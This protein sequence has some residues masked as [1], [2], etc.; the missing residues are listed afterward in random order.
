MRVPLSWLREFVTVELSPE[1]LAELLTLGGLEVEGV[2]E[3]FE[4]L[5]PVVSAEI[6]SVKPHPEA[7]RL[8]VCEVTDGKARYTI[9]SGAPG[10][11]KG[12]KVALALPG[13]VTFS[14][15]K[16]AETRIRGVTSQGMLLSPYE[17]GVSAERDR[18]LELPREAPLG[19][20]FYE[21]LG[22]SEPVL[23]V[24]ITP[25]R[26]DCLS[27]L[28]VAREV[29]A[30]TGAE[31]RRPEI[32]D[33]PMGDEIQREA[34]VEILDPD[35]CRR[36][37]GRLIKGVSVRESPFEIA[38]RLWMCGLR[39]INN[40]VDVT[41]YV[42][43]ELGQPLH[44]FDWQKIEGRRI[45]V[46]RAKE[47]EQ[48]LTLD[49]EKRL[50]SPEMLVIADSRRPVAVAGVMGGEETGVGEETRE[51]FLESAWF[52]TSSIRR[53]ARAL[54]L[55][56]DSSYRFE[57]GVDPE[58]V[59]RALERAAALILETAG[60][61]IVPG[62]LDLYPRPYRAPEIT[63]R[64]SR[65]KS[66]LRVELNREEVAGILK[67]TGGEVEVQGE[68]LRYKPPSFRYDLSLEED[69]IE[70]VARIYGYDR[71]PVS[72]PVVE[73][74]ARAPER[75]DLLISRTREVLRALGF[76]EVINYSFIS[77]ET[78]SAL[79][80]P[81]GDLRLRPL[82]LA[83]PLSEAQ[84]VMRTMLLPGLLETARFNFFREVSRLKIFEVGRVF[85]P[86]EGKL[87]EE[88]L[89]LGILMMGAAEPDFWKNLARPPE[90]YDLKGIL[91]RL[92]T[93]WRLEGLSLKPYSE[94]TFLKRGLSFSLL[95]QGEVVGFAGAL[96]TY[97]RARFE[98]S[99]PVWVA[100]IDL[101][102][103]LA[104][105]EIP[106]RYRGLPRFPATSRDLAMIVREDLPVGEIL[107]FVS[108]LAI[109]YLERVE[110]VDIYRGDPIPPGEKSVTL[111]FVY[112]SPER[113]LKD[114]E[115]NRIQE[116][117]SRKILEYFKARPR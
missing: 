49:G 78:L 43:L 91:E 35:L 74:S 54:K 34:A 76:Y 115:V 83:N 98:L 33:L 7:E 31:V 63:L 30:L 102:R 24:A 65:L 82:R 64:F 70:E 19:R 66:Y 87:P 68:S 108:G 84:S 116:E 101:S 41:N 25:N 92:L 81:E 67:R 109:P 28:G 44:A 20:P 46:R 26:G 111:R 106:K 22:L 60:G 104:L 11:E 110:V 37:A 42:M 14:G 9:V 52:E 38:R 95:A 50:L 59:I 1:A 90:I 16:I 15:E 18:L 8:R 79:E 113:T 86:Q 107:H 55:S 12:L 2:E 58:G 45:V 40:L 77:P 100:E 88:K 94:E 32:P 56:T 47:G 51:V 6:L 72:L 3:A 21:I 27:I 10:L 61:E 97:L 85:L 96:K 103:L 17:A 117:F 13:A 93:E 62:R 114:E 29:A 89:H 48:I 69:L 39:P 73:L 80:L 99:E 112:R 36:Y 23:E 105:P 71:L 5:G 53:T 75:E 57:R 4:L